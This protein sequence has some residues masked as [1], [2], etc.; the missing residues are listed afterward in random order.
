MYKDGI[1]LTPHL[2]EVRSYATF[3]IAMLAKARGGSASARE[4]AD[5]GGRDQS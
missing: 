3:F 5:R 4:L 1:H 2:T